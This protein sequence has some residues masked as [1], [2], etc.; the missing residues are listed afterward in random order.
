[1]SWRSRMTDVG[2][3]GIPVVMY[4]GLAIVMPHSSIDNSTL[5]YR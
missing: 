5:I 2:I 4:S 3:N 1:M